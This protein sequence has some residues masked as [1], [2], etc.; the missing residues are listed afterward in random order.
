MVLVLCMFD[1]FVSSANENRNSI[2]F[3][4]EKTNDIARILLD[5][6]SSADDMEGGV[7]DGR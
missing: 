1:L 4:T 7:V 2:R 3:E 6:S 5:G